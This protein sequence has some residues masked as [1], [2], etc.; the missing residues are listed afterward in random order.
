MGNV[1]SVIRLAPGRKIHPRQTLY[2]SNCFISMEQHEF[3]KNLKISEFSKWRH[4]TSCFSISLFKVRQRKRSHR[5]H[6][7]LRIKWSELTMSK[8]SS[9]GKSYRCRYPVFFYRPLFFSCSV[10]HLW[11]H[12]GKRGGHKGTCERKVRASVLRAA[13]SSCQIASFKRNC[14]KMGQHELLRP[15]KAHNLCRKRSVQVLQWSE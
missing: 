11:R 4:G 12:R 6:I 14:N 10:R 8:N 2:Q 13:I 15:F 5:F 1:C 3:S 7:R 9:S